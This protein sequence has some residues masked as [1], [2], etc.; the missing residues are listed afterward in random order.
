[1]QTKQSTHLCGLVQPPNSQFETSVLLYAATKC[2]SFKSFFLIP[3]LK[4]KSSR[5]LS[6]TAWNTASSKRFFTGCGMANVCLEIY[7]S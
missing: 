2:T 7:I 6:S 1:M 3:Q 5:A 4:V